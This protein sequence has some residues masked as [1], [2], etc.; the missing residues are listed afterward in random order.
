MRRN[1]FLKCQFC[2]EENQDICHFIMWQ[3]CDEKDVPIQDR[4]FITCKGDECQKKINN[5]PRL[6]IEVPWGAGG[7]GKFMLLCGNCE[8][9][10]EFSCSHPNLKANGGAGLLVKFTPTILSSISI[11]FTD[12]SCS[13]GG[14]P[15]A[16]FCEGNPDARK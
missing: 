4:M 7:P 11:H 16:T 15:P 5:D 1:E 2:G 12:G 6:F 10:K 3:T 14:H 13:R 9:R 8:H